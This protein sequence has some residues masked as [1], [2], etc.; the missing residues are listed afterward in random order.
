[1]SLFSAREWS[2]L[3]YH[4]VMKRESSGKN[5]HHH[6]HHPIGNFFSF[7]PDMP[8]LSLCISHTLLS[9]TLAVSP[10]DT[11]LPPPPFDHGDKP[12]AVTVMQHSGHS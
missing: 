2:A 4:T 11:E 9:G 10:T 5:S 12:K 3:F 6:H 1:M 8:F 7:L